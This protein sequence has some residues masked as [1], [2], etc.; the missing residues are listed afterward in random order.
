M[1]GAR[2]LAFALTLAGL[3]APPAAAQTPAASPG[4]REV[5]VPA[6]DPRD[7]TP[8]APARAEIRLVVL[9]D[10]FPQ[11]LADAVASGL[12]RALDVRVVPLGRS[13]LPH[14][15]FYPPRGRYRADALLEHLHGLVAVVPAGTRILALTDVDISTSKGP[16]ADWGVFGLADLGGPAGVV[17]SYRLQRKARD[18]DQVRFRVVSTA[19]H[20]AGHTLGL[21]HCPEA[22]CVMQDAE[23]GIA[24]TDGGT[25]LLGPA[26]RAQLDAT[27]PAR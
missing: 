15:A 23:G 8:A 1:N 16:H 4:A 5:A 2:A 3:S 26:C 13:P 22:R 25:G 17:S 24:N 7:A 9:G 19:V 20:E 21:P 10:R 6:G 12:A 27:L 18:A 14:A 11:S